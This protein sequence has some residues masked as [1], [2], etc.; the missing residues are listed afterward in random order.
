MPARTI[1]DALADS[2][3]HARASEMHAEANPTRKQRDTNAIT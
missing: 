1:S 2:H 3:T